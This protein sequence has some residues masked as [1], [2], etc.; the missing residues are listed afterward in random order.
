MVR[1]DGGPFFWVGSGDRF[2]IA[3]EGTVSLWGEW[4]SGELNSCAMVDGCGG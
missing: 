4:Y 2:E 3:W 1:D